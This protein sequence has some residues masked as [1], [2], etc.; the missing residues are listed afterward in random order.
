[1]AEPFSLKDD[2]FNPRTVGQLAAEYAAGVPG[3]D[4]PRFEA[5][6][7]AGFPERELMARMEWM[8]DCLEQQ[9]APDFPT[10]ADPLEAAMPPPL[11]P[12]LRDDD[13]GHFKPW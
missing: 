9:L 11:D 12:A 13:F 8:A 5:A 2:L 6:A 7:L 3:F 10:M 4:G 1:M